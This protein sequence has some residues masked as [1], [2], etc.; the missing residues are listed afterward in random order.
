MHELIVGKTARAQFR[1]MNVGDH[2]KL[3]SIDWTV[4]IPKV[5]SD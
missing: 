1:D 2:I 3:R 5:F 4:V